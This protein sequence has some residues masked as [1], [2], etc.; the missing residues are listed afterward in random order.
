MNFDPNMMNPEM[1]K[2]VMESFSQ[3]SDDQLSSMMSGM[4]K[5]RNY[6]CKN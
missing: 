4:G 5:N 1:M 6:N 2:N 3:M